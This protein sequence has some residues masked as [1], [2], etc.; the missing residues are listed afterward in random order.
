MELP[1]TIVFEP[2]S[3][4]ELRALLRMRGHWVA[5]LIVALT[6]GTAYVVASGARADAGAAGE[7]VALVLAS[8]P[9][10]AAVQV[11]GHSR[12]LAPLDLMVEPGTHQISLSASGAL[13]GHYTL[14]VGPEGAALHASLWRRQ[15]DLMRLRPPLPG[16]A[17]TEVQLLENDDLGLSIAFPPG[18]EAQA[19]RL[20]PRSGVLELALNNT[21]GTRLTFAADG[22]RLAYLGSDIGPP[23]PGAA[24]V[25][26]ADSALASVVWLVDTAEAVA[27]ST[28]WRAPLE[29]TEQLVDV[30]WSPHEDRL[31]VASHQLLAG[32]A[33]RSRLWFVDADGEHANAVLSL[34]SEV[35]PGSARWSPDGQSVVFV[36]HAAEVNALC[37]LQVNGL[38]RYLADLDSSLTPPL[39]YPPLVWSTTGQRLLFVA[40]HQHPPGVPLSFLQPDLQHALY[41]ATLE[42]PRPRAL[43]DTDIDVAAWREDGQVVG[44]GHAGADSALTLRLLLA[45]GSPDQQLVELP[46]RAGPRY[47]AEWDVAR[48]RLLVVSQSSSGAIDY[49]LARLGLESAK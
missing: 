12:G 27:P 17:L 16:A 44:L 24:A 22:H 36:V 35:V 21:A 47:A 5:G 37:W 13:D 30:S 25:W 20:E 32:G 11:D 15:P 41:V 10:G 4:S 46:L 8:E 7:P 43:G 19:W 48:A 28:G 31:L 23:L 29:S 6:I 45:G 49:W 3:R 26:S 18:R 38:F 34:P 40:P 14:D 9:P 2:P 42:D 1:F 33:T 39:P